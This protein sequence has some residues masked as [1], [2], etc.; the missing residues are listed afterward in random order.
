MFAIL[1]GVVFSAH[2][3]EY[4]DNSKSVPPAR[5][6]T[7]SGDNDKYVPPATANTQY[8]DDK[9]VAPVATNTR[10]GSTDKYGNPTYN[11]NTPYRAD[12][13]YRGAHAHFGDED[14]NYT[15]YVD[16]N[17]YGATNLTREG[18]KEGKW[19]D[20]L[21]NNAEPTSFHSAMFCVITNY[22]GGKSVGKKNE[23]DMLG[24]LVYESRYTDGKLDE[25]RRYHE[26]NLLLSEDFY[27][28]GK[29]QGL[30]KIFYEDG[31]LKSETNYVNGMKKG[32]EKIYYESGRMKEENNYDDDRE[33]KHKFYRD[34]Y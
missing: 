34:E 20:Y 18:L 30:S 24:N 1:N 9:Y 21:D 7:Q 26:N 4:G 10:N 32:S 3:Q 33:V 28:D 6:T 31:I 12:D 5:A 11:S 17:R 29:K 13:K 27:V 16:N 23:Y 22:K 15:H 8:G 14:M 19:I 25:I 2:A